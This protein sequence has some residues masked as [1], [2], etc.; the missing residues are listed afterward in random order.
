MRFPKEKVLIT[1]QFNDLKKKNDIFGIAKMKD[2]VLE[3]YEVLEPNIFSK[4]VSSTFIIGNFDDTIKI[5]N[6][7]IA[8]NIET[9]DILYYTL[10]SLIARTD[11]YQAMSLIK[12][13]KILNLEEIKKFHSLEGANYSNLLNF[14]A[15]LS[16]S[17]LTL[18]VVNFIEGIAREMTGNI[19]VDRDYLLFRFFDLIN[20]VYEI[21]YPYEIIEELSKAIKLIF[22]LDV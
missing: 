13:S 7:L 16:S 17:T 19:D 11:I 9:F 1:T 10:L 18:L 3:N 12:K 20:M 8:K 4:L 14:S 2:Q 22:N 6:E 15:A 21:G 5:G